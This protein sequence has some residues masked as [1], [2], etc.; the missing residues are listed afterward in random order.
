VRAG[1][2]G[3]EYEEAWERQMCTHIDW[4][5]ASAPVAGSVAGAEVP[6]ESG[7]GQRAAG[8]QRRAYREQ[9]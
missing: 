3:G 9:T 6:I 7:L 8:T 2:R 4:V 1:I 5:G